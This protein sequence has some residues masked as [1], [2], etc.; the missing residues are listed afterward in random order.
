M[1]A[2][3][4]HILLLSCFRVL[5]NQHCKSHWDRELEDSWHQNLGDVDANANVCD[6]TG[7]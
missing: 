4:Y 6:G 3:L 5:V 2:Q 1:E 7:G